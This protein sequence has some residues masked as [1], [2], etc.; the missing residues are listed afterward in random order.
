MAATF[1]PSARIDY[2]FVGSP[3]AGG[4]GRVERVALVGDQ[5]VDDVWPSHHAG[6][7]VDL[8]A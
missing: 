8:A 6:I 5:A 1:E 4:R 2:I 3:A 7:V